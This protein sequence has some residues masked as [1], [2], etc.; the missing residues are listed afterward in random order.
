MSDKHNIMVSIDTFSLQGKLLVASPD[1]KDPRFK[2]RVIYMCI[3]DPIDAIGLIINQA[4]PGLFLDEV[5]EFEPLDIKPSK[6]TSVISR[7]E[8]LY[9]GPVGTNRGFVLHSPLTEAQHQTVKETSTQLTDTLFLTSDKAILPTL[10]S[11]NPPDNALLAIGYSGWS[12]GQLE[13]EIMS[14]CWIVVDSDDSLIFDM[15]FENKRSKALAK[16]GI[17]PQQLARQ[18][19]KA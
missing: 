11:D 3:H 1:M 2:G 15:E 14:N 17:S 5:I 19:G 8:V 7:Q 10:V 13:Q 16:L 9:G 4:I 6:K 12:P 18:S